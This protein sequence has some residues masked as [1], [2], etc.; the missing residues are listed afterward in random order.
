MARKRWCRGGG[1]RALPGG[2][3]DYRSFD[4]K[5]WRIVQLLTAEHCIALVDTSLI[6][7]TTKP[8]QGGLSH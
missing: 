4:K 8:A 1:Q 6:P 7:E 5:S 3:S 2:C